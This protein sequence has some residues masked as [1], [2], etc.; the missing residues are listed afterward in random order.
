MTKLEKLK[1]LK[2]DLINT[3]FAYTKV[4]ILSGEVELEKSLSLKVVENAITTEELKISLGGT[5][6][7]EYRRAIQQMIFKDLVE[8][9]KERFKT[10][11]EIDV[12]S[13]VGKM[14]RSDTL[15]AIRVYAVDHVGKYVYAEV[16]PNNATGRPLLSAEV[17]R[18]PGYSM[19]IKGTAQIKETRQEDKPVFTPSVELEDLL[20][21]CF[22]ANGATV[23]VASID[24]TYR[25]VNVYKMDNVPTKGCVLLADILQENFEGYG[26]FIHATPTPSGGEYVSGLDCCDSE[27]VHVDV[28]KKVLCVKRLYNNEADNSKTVFPY[29]LWGSK[30][31]SFKHV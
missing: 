14:F 24:R 8:L 5:Q 20:G 25:L 1:K 12:E 22:I 28:A 21:K 6:I 19:D 17:K 31:W 3:N 18:Y 7:D 23:V 13:L 29:K 26:I 9:Q 4:R 11:L 10:D 30:G 27:I 16:V 15:E 2:E